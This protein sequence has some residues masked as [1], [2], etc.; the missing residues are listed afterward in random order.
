MSELMPLPSWDSEATWATFESGLY[1][2]EIA[3]VEVQ[4]CDDDLDRYRELVDIS[5]PDIVVETGTRAGGSALFFRSL[6]LQVVT[7]DTS[8]Q[9][10]DR[11]PVV[12]PGIDWVTGSSIGD[13][14]W[15]RVVP[16][17]VGKRVMVSLDSDHHSAHVQAEIVLW[18]P[19]V[20]PGCYLVVEDAC[21]EMWE[22]VRARRGGYQI[23]EFGGPLDA[24]RKQLD[25]PNGAF[26]RDEMLESLTP[27]SHSPVGWWRKHD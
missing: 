2:G 27:V 18:G 19:M 6:G 14:V 17:L 24:I 3:Q 8:P 7:I 4:K 10:G 12:G 16:Q 11:P 22:P 20:S 9:F 13:D 23:P 26:W 1:H 25:H 5:Q 15:S 21:F